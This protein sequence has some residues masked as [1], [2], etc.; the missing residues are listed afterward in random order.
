MVKR[1]RIAK[2]PELPTPDD[3]VKDGG[4]DPEIQ[5]P[6]EQ[7][8]TKPE[9]AVKPYPHRI[10]YDTTREQYRSLKRAAFEEERTMNDIVREAVDEWL[11][12]RHY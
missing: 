9:Q 12:S 7:P 3:W 2:R 10:S 8:E 4:A 11:K 1:P 6:V 5:Q